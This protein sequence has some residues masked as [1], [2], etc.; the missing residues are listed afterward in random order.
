MP[1]F[2]Q[3]AFD[4]IEPL[5]P[6]RPKYPER[7]FTCIGAGT[8]AADVARCREGIKRDNAILAK[9]IPPERFHISLCGIGDYVRIPSRV[10]FA[11]MRAGERIMLSPFEVVLYRAVTFP[12][13]RDDRPTVLLA[14]SRELREL[15]DLLFGHLRREGLRA[16]EL[17]EPHMTL[18]YSARSIRP[19]DIDPIRFRVDRFYLIHSE[20]GLT[21]YNVLG[22]W[23]LNGSGVATPGPLAFGSM[24]A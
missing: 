8:A 14:E 16:G 20:R 17:R 10:P 18:F 11:A 13:F 2:I 15:G 12:G 9:G 3:P 22:C 4:F 6:R 23:L 24:A 19:V 7:V 1:E 21:R 5:D